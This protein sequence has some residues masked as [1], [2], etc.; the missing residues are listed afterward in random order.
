MTIEQLGINAMSLCT[1]GKVLS[2]HMKVFKNFVGPRAGR[3]VHLMVESRNIGDIFN[4]LPLLSD[5]VI[6]FAG[7]QVLTQKLNSSLTT[8]VINVGLVNVVD[9]TVHSFV[10]LRHVLGPV[11]PGQVMVYSR[12][13][14][15]AGSESIRVDCDREE[16]GQVA[17]T[18]RL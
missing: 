8:L 1:A 15:V 16:F 7:V 12:V 17:R 3:S 9:E 13:Q 10:T 5:R 6:H 4:M 2:N 11:D 14:Q 18:R